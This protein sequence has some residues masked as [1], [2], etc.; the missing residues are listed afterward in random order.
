MTIPTMRLLSAMLSLFL[1]QSLFGQAWMARH[2]L[3]A[4]QYQIEFTLLTSQGYRPIV[5]SGYASGNRARYAAIFV[6]ENA[7]PQWVAR[8]GLSAAEYQ[9]D[10]D[11]MV[12]KGFQLFDVSGYHV[13]GKDLYAT[14]WEKRTDT[15]Q[16][17]ARHGL[18]A[19]EYQQEFNKWEAE[20]YYLFK[21]SG[22][23]GRYAAIWRKG[24]PAVWQAR[25]GIVGSRPYQDEF[26]RLY[27][28]GSCSVLWR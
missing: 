11:R 22:Y 6:K 5:V 21:I 18:S 17:V 16:W 2:N 28:Q 14:I 20:G 13:G 8:H 19:T 25:H 3:S 7:P 9:T 10:F 12:R 4:A 15:P 24:G 26:E 27:Y 23:A 1:C